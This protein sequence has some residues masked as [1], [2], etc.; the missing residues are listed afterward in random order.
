MEKNE[1]DLTSRVAVVTG[2]SRGI[3]YHI[4]IALAKYGANLVL[5]S[6]TFTEVEKLANEII[7]MGRRAIA[8]QLD[9]T[10][11][12]QFKDFTDK[13]IKE[14]GRIDVLVNNAGI[15]RQEWAEDFTEENWDLILN[16]NLKGPFFLAQAIGKI[17]IRQKFGKIIN[18]SSDAGSVGL[19]RRAAYCASKGGLNLLT[20]NLA[21]EW[22][23]YN[24]NVN[25]VAPAFIETPL[26]EPMLKD[27]CFMDWIMANTPLGRIG[28]PS[29]VAT[30]VVFLASRAS[31]YMTGHIMLIDGGWTAH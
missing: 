15:N 28:K 1:F 21:I 14:F 10:E 4:A 17:M 25:A 3:G 13:V 19:P 23:K 24:I 7:K 26:T 2:A 5:C 6:R 11:T 8:I 18:I 12:K 22:A 9:I 30:A 16:T 20:K 29:E 31:D 27:P